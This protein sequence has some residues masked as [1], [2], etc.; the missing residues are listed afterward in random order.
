[1]SWIDFL[2]A[3]R[4]L[5]EVFGGP[6]L[7]SPAIVLH[8]LTLHRDGPRARLRFDLVEFPVDPP[9]KW[10]AASCNTVQVTVEAAGG[11]DVLEVSG[12]TMSGEVVAGLDDLAD[13]RRELTLLST[14]MRARIVSRHFRVATISA[15][16]QE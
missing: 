12:F 11:L 13:G 16:R 2:N 9:A 7:R 3:D 4:G 1:M 14:D 8:E 5:A 15:H 6:L 10:A